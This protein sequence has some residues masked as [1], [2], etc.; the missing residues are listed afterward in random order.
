MTIPETESFSLWTDML[1]QHGADALVA[2]VFHA[3]IADCPYRD[4]R[5]RE[6]YDPYASELARPFGSPGLAGYI[7]SYSHTRPRRGAN[8]PRQQPPCCS[9]PGP[10]SHKVSTDVPSKFGRCG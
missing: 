7:A 1:A 4:G 2:D 3:L 5:E 10:I 9:L 8:R 6:R